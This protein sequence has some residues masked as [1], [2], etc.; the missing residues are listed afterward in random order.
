MKQQQHEN[1]HIPPHRGDI[2]QQHGLKIVTE[3]TFLL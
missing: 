1:L 3:T 2:Q